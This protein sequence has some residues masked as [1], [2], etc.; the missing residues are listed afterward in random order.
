M[1]VVQLVVMVVVVV[2]VKN[3]QM[4]VNIHVLVVQLMNVL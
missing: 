4:I 3:V 2:L 1:D